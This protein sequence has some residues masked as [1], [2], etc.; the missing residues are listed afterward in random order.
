MEIVIKVKHLYFI[1]A[2]IIF[3]T[4]LLIY[5]S[6]SDDSSGITSVSALELKFAELGKA[7]TNVCGG[8][9]YVYSMDN[10]A[11]L[12]GSCCSPMEFH[13]YKEQV[14]GLKD[15]KE[16]YSYLGNDLRLISDDPY[17]IPVSLAEELLEYQKRIKLTPEQQLIYDEAVKL[18]HEGGPCCCKCWRW[19]AFDG[20][21]KKL[22]TDYGFNS[23]QIAEL[24]DIE[25]GCGGSGHAH[26]YELETNRETFEPQ[27]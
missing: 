7:N 18:S 4:G 24:W 8:S 21:A 20:Q 19:Y 17:D 14:G 10:D 13:M 22:I 6:I 16:K 25:D 23:E 1:M 9:Q 11:R 27:N 3:I 2:I 12:Q 15:I 26:D 5:S